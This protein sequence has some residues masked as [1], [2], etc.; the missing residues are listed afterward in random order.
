MLSSFLDVLLKVLIHKTHNLLQEEIIRAV[1]NMVERNFDVY[2]VQFIP[3]FLMNMVGLTDHQKSQLHQN[4]KRHQVKQ[5]T[6]NK[7]GKFF[8]LCIGEDNDHN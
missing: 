7:S 5:I 3:H 2:F 6:L 4:Y 1:H 8:L